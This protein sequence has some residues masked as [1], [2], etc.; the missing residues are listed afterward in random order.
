MAA[1]NFGTNL[2]FGYSCHVKKLH[3]EGTNVKT[4]PVIVTLMNAFGYFMYIQTYIHVVLSVLVQ[5]PFSSILYCV[6]I[7]FLDVKCILL[8]TIE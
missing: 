4:I 1:G 6:E 3:T 2:N 7:Y 8:R 5:C